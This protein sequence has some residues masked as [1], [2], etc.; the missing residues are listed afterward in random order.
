MSSTRARRFPPVLKA[1]PFEGPNGRLWLLLAASL[2]TA[3]F[4]AAHLVRIF[5]PVVLG[6]DALPLDTVAFHAAARAALEALAAGGERANLYD[7][8]AFADVI[9]GPTGLLWLYPPTALLPLA[10]LGLVSLPVAKAVLAALNL[11][12]SFALFRRVAA[13]RADIAALCLFSPALFGALFIGQVTPLFALLFVYGLL[14]ARTRPIAAG[15][16]LALLTMKPQY[17]LLAIPFLLGLGAYRALAA[18]AL[19][20]LGFIALSGVLFGFDQWTFFFASITDGG[21]AMYYETGGHTARATP[22]DA[23]KALGVAPPPALVL[24]GPLLALAAAAVFWV[25]RRAPLALSFAFTAFA[26]AATAPYFMYYDALIVAAG[27]VALWTLARPPGAALWWALLAAWFAPFAPSMI[28]W[29]LIPA[30][31]WLLHAG[32]AVALAVR[33]AQTP[34][35]RAASPSANALAMRR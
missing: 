16:C 22:S 23:L 17:G 21:H 12:A 9:G 27:S 35:D 34:D 6:P 33:A 15:L 10:P 25:A 28:G 14:G 3:K 18:A 24:Y 4:Y 31:V 1:S 7:P 19:G 13:G 11:A 26:A 20:A 2:V 30:A 29:P 5:F 32:L 8:P